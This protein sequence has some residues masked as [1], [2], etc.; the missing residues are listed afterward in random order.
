[1][2]AAKTPPSQCE[3]LILTVV[4]LFLNCSFSC[5]LSYFTLIFATNDPRFSRGTD[6]LLFQSPALLIDERIGFSRHSEGPE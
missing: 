3:L 5:S 4:V 6:A 2:I 1:M